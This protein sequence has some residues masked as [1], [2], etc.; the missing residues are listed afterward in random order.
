[1]FVP[2]ELAGQ[3]LDCFLATGKQDRALHW[4]SIDALASNHHLG[5]PGRKRGV[6][7]A[8]ILERGTTSD[9]NW[10]RR[11]VDD[12]RR[13]SVVALGGPQVRLGSDG[14]TRKATTVRMQR[15]MVLTIALALVSVLRSASLAGQG[16][17]I[18]VFNGNDLRGLKVEGADLEVDSGVLRVRAGPGWVRTENPRGDFV[19]RLEVRLTGRNAEAGVFVRAY[20][21]LNQG[22]SPP[23]VGYEI[24]VRD[25]PSAGEIIRHDL[26]ARALRIDRKSAG[27]VFEEGGAWHRY[28]IECAGTTLKVAVDGVQMAAMAELENPSGYLAFRTQTGIAELR[29]VELETMSIPGVGPDEQVIEIDAQ[30]RPGSGVGFAVPRLPKPVPQYT[31]EALSQRIQGTVRLS[32]V[33]APDG[34]AYD[35]TVIKSLDPKFGLDQS[36]VKTLRQTRFTPG[37]RD[38]RPV[39]VRI[40]V[41]YSFTARF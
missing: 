40:V 25:T 11:R 31:K 9:F 6:G 24:A 15:Q 22:Q 12:V 19:L 5:G 13:G 8:R 37:T 41:D 38:G 16:N 23:R 34:V 3:A 14:M 20:P 27:P 17:V 7:N 4:V 35:I 1:L 29:N 18:A 21:A 2:E 30:L 32:A 28:E 10:S 33:V 39:P 36:A 26:G